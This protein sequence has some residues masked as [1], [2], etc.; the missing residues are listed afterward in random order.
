MNRRVGINR[1]FWSRRS[2]KRLNIRNHQ[3][4]EGKVT[5]AEPKG[6]RNPVSL[7]DIEISPAQVVDKMLERSPVE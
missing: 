3:R 5:T 1:Y 6:P 7:E 4:S 2:V